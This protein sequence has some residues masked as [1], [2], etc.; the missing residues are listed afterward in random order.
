MTPNPEKT[1]N[2]KIKEMFM[3][4]IA[5]QDKKA[6]EYYSKALTTESRNESVTVKAFYASAY[7]ASYQHAETLRLFDSF[8]DSLRCL[9]EGLEARIWNLDKRIQNIAE[10][11]GIDVSGMKKEVVDL[12]E[13]LKSKIFADVVAA[14][15]KSDEEEKKR[16]K[17]GKECF[18]SFTRSR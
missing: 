10:E 15:K 16:E 14:L 4:K 17:R 2:E 9:N 7:L 5:G 1:I 11:T 18:D 3:G 12:K 8:V 13:F 6:E